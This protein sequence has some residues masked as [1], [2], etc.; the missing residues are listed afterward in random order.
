MPPPEGA[1]KRSDNYMAA[2]RLVT[3]SSILLAVALAPAQAAERSGA[4][5][6][7]GGVALRDQGAQ[8]SGIS[9]GIPANALSRF[10][11]STLDDSLLRTSLYGGYRWTNDVAVEASVNTSDPYS[12]RPA[13]SGAV[14]RG[15]GVFPS[16]SSLGLT[17][18]QARSWNVDVYTSWGFY[19]N[20]AL[21]GRLGYAQTDAAPT[22]TGNYAPASD[23][24]R[25]RDGM[26]YGV[27]IRY[28]M[29]SSL[30]LRL[31]YGRFGRFAGEIGSAP[32]ESDQVTIGLQF[33][34]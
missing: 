5:G 11:L 25:L 7:Y 3:L 18:L 21:Y 33:R 16:A 13:D 34:F 4:A 30:G 19:R 22:L 6:F 32:L 15:M 8:A 1:T 29:T 20:F 17:D 27:G 31:E 14:R 9:L 28:D 23:T 12:L 24:R 2:Q 10:T 26:N